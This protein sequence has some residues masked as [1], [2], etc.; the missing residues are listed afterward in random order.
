MGYHYIQ[1]S[2]LLKNIDGKIYMLQKVIFSL[3]K[4]IKSDISLVKNI[5]V[6]MTCDF[7]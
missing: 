5:N 4:N 1:I 7:P 6:W 3:V 2:E